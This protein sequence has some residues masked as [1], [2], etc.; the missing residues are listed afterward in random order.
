MILL[1]GRIVIIL[2]VYDNLVMLV[3]SIF[4][5]YI[6]LPF[7][8]AG[9]R[10]QTGISSYYLECLAIHTDSARYNKTIIYYLTK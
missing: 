2:N 6:L 10:V 7:E 3:S 1:D 4:Q 9:R 5:E 8:R